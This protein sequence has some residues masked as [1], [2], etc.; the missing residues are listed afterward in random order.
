MTQPDTTTD[1]ELQR[2]CKE[3]LS[4]ITITQQQVIVL[5]IV[6][7]DGSLNNTWQQS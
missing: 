1:K 4:S 5:A 3:Y 7:Q 6:N 2:L